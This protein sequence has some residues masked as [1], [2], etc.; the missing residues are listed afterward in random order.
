MVNLIRGQ[1][2]KLSDLLPGRQFRVGFKADGGRGAFD[3]SCFI[4]DGQDRVLSDGAIVFY[5][6]ICSECGGVALLG[7]HGG[8]SQVAEIDLDLLPAGA[9]KVAF[10]IT[11]D[12]RDISE[13]P[14][15]HVRLMHKGHEAARYEFSG[16]DFAGETALIAMEL[17]IKDVWRVRVVGQGFVG[18]GL[19]H[20]IGH[21]GGEV[22]ESAPDASSGKSQAGIPD[23]Q[24]EELLARALSR[25]SPAQALLDGP[26]SGPEVALG[27]ESSARELQGPAVLH[28]PRTLDGRGATLWTASGP[29]LLV[30]GEGVTV[31]N[32]RVE[33]T[34]DGARGDEA[35]AVVMLPGARADFENVEVRGNVRGVPGEE[36]EWNLPASLPLGILGRAHEYVF[37]AGVTLPVPCTVHASVSGMRVEPES[38]PAGT[39]ELRLHVRGGSFFNDTVLHGRIELRTRCF[40]RAIM[41][42]GHVVD[43][44]A[45]GVAPPPGPI[46]L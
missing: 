9:R 6:Q 16:M 46:R 5:N 27:P 20:L 25:N 30:A 29:A 17:Y 26:K 36:G 3:I 21:F 40:R 8:D 11:L 37:V 19:E 45:Q 23:A 24:A 38:L 34:K 35:C 33:V 42:T 7:P 39:G 31:R 2:A 10:A 43:A 44:A 15:G 32:L 22:A 1:R 12:G 13:I 18:K 14:S 41:V 28:G 4:L